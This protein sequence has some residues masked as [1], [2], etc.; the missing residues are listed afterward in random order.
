MTDPADYLTSLRFVND[1][2]IIPEHVVE[3]AER[4]GFHADSGIRFRDPEP[5]QEEPCDD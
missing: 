2:N 1:R 4:L 5:E 3:E